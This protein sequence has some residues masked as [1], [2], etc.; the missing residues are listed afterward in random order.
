MFSFVTEESK[1][2]KI[3]KIEGT[4]HPI[5]A[6]YEKLKCVLVPVDSNSEEFQLIEQY[7]QNSR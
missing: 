1:Q 4:E 6:H 2:R 5:D 7:D 3:N